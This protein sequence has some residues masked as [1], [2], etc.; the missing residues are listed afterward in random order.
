V[1]ARP[2]GADQA[3]DLVGKQAQFPVDIGVIHS[4]KLSSIA[5]VDGEERDM[6]GRG[7][8][9]MNGRGGAGHERTGRADMDDGEERDVNSGEERT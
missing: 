1:R 3:E 5:L 7:E 2:G 6:N 8:R 4:F 9:D